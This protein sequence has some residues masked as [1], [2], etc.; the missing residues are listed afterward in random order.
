[1]DD[2][3]DHGYASHEIGVTVFFDGIENIHNKLDSN[4]THYHDNIIR[5]N[6]ILYFSLL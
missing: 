3:V 2:F 5:K 1:M 4:G 6:N